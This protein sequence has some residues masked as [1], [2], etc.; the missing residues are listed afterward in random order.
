MVIL[1]NL[2]R[3]RWRAAL[4]LEPLEED[5]AST[6]PVADGRLAVAALTRAITSLPR[7]QELI[8]QMVLEGEGSPAVIAATLGL[9]V[10]TVMSRL[11]RAQLRSRLGLEADTPVANLL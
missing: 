5:S 6:P 11:A 2:V 1:R 4:D 10:G 7:D 9:P 8:M 3:A